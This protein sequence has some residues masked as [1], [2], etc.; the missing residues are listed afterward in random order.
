MVCIVEEVRV[1]KLGVEAYS[2]A[3]TENIAIIELADDGVNSCS[4]EYFLD[5]P[6]II[7][8]NSNLW[9]YGYQIPGLK[10]CVECN[11]GHGR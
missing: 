4:W 9:G 5:F 8:F 7:K 2:C 10:S 11:G 1:D 6:N 3:I